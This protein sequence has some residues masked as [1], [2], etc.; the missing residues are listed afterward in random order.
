MFA[1]FSIGTAAMLGVLFGLSQWM[2]E[3]TP[4]ALLAGPA[5]VS[6]LLVLYAAGLV[7]QRLGAG[8]MAEL[9]E[10]LDALLGDARGGRPEEADAQSGSV[11]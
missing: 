10:A 1:A 2:L 9:R 6:V 4:W 7:G 8:Q 3:T 11:R 5:G